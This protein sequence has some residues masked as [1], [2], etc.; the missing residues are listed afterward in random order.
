VGQ[1]KGRGE[2]RISAIKINHF[3]AIS[4]SSPAAG[5]PFIQ[6][7][8]FAYDKMGN[9]AYRFKGLSILSY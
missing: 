7:G 3:L 2:E 6:V 8:A 5:L 1:G 4:V 9:F